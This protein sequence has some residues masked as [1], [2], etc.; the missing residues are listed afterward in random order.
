M[1]PLI[2]AVILQQQV[3]DVFLAPRSPR[4]RHMQVTENSARS[5]ARSWTGTV[6]SS[7]PRVRARGWSR[8]CVP[9]SHADEQLRAYLHHGEP[10]IFVALLLEHITGATLARLPGA[11][12]K[13]VVLAIIVAGIECCAAFRPRAVPALSATAPRAPSSP[14]SVLTL[15]GGG[16]TQQAP[17]RRRLNYYVAS[18]TAVHTDTRRKL[19]TMRIIKVIRSAPPIRKTSWRMSTYESTRRSRRHRGG[20]GSGKSTMLKHMIAFI[21]RGGTPDRR[22]RSQPHQNTPPTPRLLGDHRRQHPPEV[23]ACLQGARGSAT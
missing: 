8:P 1:G 16:C 22:R 13:A 2:T 4:N 7:L 9:R 17:P 10:W 11:S 23:W 15:T 5:D 18:K 14:A 6:Y 3:T 12:P 19:S 21:P 20:A